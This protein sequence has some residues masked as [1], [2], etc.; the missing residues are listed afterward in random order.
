[1]SIAH[2]SLRRVSSRYPLRY[3]RQYL[4][5]CTSKASK[6]STFEVSVRRASARRSSCTHQRVVET[7]F[8]FLYFNKKK[9]PNNNKKNPI[10]ARAL[11]LSLSLSLV[12]ECL[13]RCI[14]RQMRLKRKLPEG[15]EARARG[16]RGQRLRHTCRPAARGQRQ[17]PEAEAYL[18]TR[19]RPD[20]G[21]CI[22]RRMLTAALLLL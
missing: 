4:Y 17:G 11:S 21:R 15:P 10:A 1:M 6:L 16:A 13:S 3:L 18:S 14:G 20:A 2:W 19:I 9:P 8:F 7:E 12:Y 5:F 22:C